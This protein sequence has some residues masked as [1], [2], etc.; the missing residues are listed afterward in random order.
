[1]D[2][3]GLQEFSRRYWDSVPLGIPFRRFQ[4]IPYSRLGLTFHRKFD[5]RSHKLIRYPSVYLNVF[6]WPR[7]RL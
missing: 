5:Q 1:M 6:V 3:E 4:K 7:I 2:Y